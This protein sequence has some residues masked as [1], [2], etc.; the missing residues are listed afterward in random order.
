MPDGDRLDTTLTP[1]GEGVKP[2]TVSELAAL[3]AQLDDAITKL[4][5]DIDTADKAVDALASWANVAV[6]VIDVVAPIL[7]KAMAAHAVP[8]ADQPSKLNGFL[9]GLLD[10]SQ[11]PKPDRQAA[12]VSLLRGLLA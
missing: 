1:G 8:A 12:V 3:L 10:V 11:T 4:H 5:A 9:S 6:H 2:Q 7:N